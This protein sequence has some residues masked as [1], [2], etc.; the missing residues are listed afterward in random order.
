MCSLKTI[1]TRPKPIHSL[2]SPQTRWQGRHTFCS[3]ERLPVVLPIYVFV[4]HC[5][6]QLWPML[7]GLIWF[8][9]CHWSMTL[10]FNITKVF[11]FIIYKVS[12]NTGHI[13]AK[14]RLNIAS[15][16]II[17]SVSFLKFWSFYTLFSRIPP[18]LS[19]SFLLLEIR[20]F[21]PLFRQFC[22]SLILVS[23]SIYCIKGQ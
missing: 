9:Q 17:V 23:L 3:I 2:L 8:S 7:F 15:L 5:F 11:P 21:H 19:I 12:I 13:I 16:S 6:F 20:P 18:V 10:H 14:Y 4:F 22:P 1:P